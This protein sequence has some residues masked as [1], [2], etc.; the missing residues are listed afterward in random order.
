MLN[1]NYIR[2]RD[3]DSF[4]EQLNLVIDAQPSFGFIENIKTGKLFL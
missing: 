4:K 1:E 2:V 3:G